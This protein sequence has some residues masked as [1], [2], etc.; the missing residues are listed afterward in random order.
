MTVDTV[1]EVGTARERIF[2]I[3]ANLATQKE[4]LAGFEVTA[5]ELEHRL[6]RLGA[7]KQALINRHARGEDVSDEL[8]E[9]RREI[10]DGQSE[11]GDVSETI[12][13]V[14]GIIEDTERSRRSA[15]SAEQSTRATA[16]GDEARQKLEVARTTAVRLVA[17]IKEAATL[18]DTTARLQGGNAVRGDL[19]QWAEQIRVWAQLV[20]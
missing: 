13:T 2:Q 19:H 3:E 6:E 14:K 8:A 9:T 11:L 20:R 10:V 18:F 5:H 17:E 4:R 12:A 15:I 16:T 1:D 7:T